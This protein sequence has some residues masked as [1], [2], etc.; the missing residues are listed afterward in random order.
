M[1]KVI[2]LIFC[3]LI[4]GQAKAGPSVG[5]LKTANYNH[6]LAKLFYIE[7]KGG[8]VSNPKVRVI[9]GKRVVYDKLI[10]IENNTLPFQKISPPILQDL[11][12]DWE[13]EIIIE[14]STDKNNCCNYTLIYRYD[15]SLRNYTYIAHDWKSIIKGRKLEDIDK[16]GT[17]EFMS[18]DMRFLNEYGDKDGSKLPLQIW[19]YEKSKM[20][21]VTSEFPELVKADAKKFWEQ[22][23]QARKAKKYDVF[24]VK[25]TL[26]A[27]LADKYNLGQAEDGWKLVKEAYKGKDKKQFINYLE[28]FFQ[29]TGFKKQ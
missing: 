26:R 10:K 21:D 14:L 17:P 7:E 3:F 8:G 1:K 24:M 27:Y 15:P 9:R 20:I 22:F 13:P 23:T 16:D 19:H 11:D 25:D 4:F 6:I 2:A 12:E 29:T 28:N 18:R 5:V